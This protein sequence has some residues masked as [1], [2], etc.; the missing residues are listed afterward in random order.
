MTSSMP[1]ANRA[2][3]TFGLALPCGST[4]V[5]DPLRG[6]DGGVWSVVFA[7]DR[8]LASAGNDGKVRLRNPATGAAV[9]D[10]LHGHDGGV[11]SVAFAPDG[12]L[13][14]SAGPDGRVRI[15]KVRR[16]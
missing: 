12:Q 11:L 3:T 15:R 1:T 14:A 9:G 16:P 5:G 8:L 4:P 2:F 7:S 6:H 10:P 13:L